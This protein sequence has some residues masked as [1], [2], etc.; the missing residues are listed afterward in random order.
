M[1]VEDLEI[2]RDKSEFMVEIGQ[3]TLSLPNGR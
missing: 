2:G 3:A 1:T